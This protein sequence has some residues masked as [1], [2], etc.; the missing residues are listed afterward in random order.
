MLKDK[1]INHE[2]RQ[3]KLHSTLC[4]ILY[5]FF[6][7]ELNYQTQQSGVLEL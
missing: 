3:P 5:I 1:R 4:T 6:P 2:F 7:A